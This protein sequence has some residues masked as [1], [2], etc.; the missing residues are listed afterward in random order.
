VTWMVFWMQKASRTMRADLERGAERALVSGS[1]WAIVVIG[2]VSVAR[3]GIE[4][5][6]M[7]WSLVRSFGNAPEAL[8]GA[9]LG[10]VLAV[11][12]GWLLQRGMVR[13]DLRVFFTWTGAVLIVA[14]AGVLAYG[15]H[16]LQEAGVLPGPF[17]SAAP[18]D[19]ASGAVATGVAG[20]PFGYAFDVSGAVSP[21]GPL[22]AVLQATVGFTPRMTW[23]QIVVWVAYLVVV[24]TV[25]ARRV[26]ASSAAARRR[27]AALVPLPEG[28][29]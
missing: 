23:L 11:A 24:G 17:T 29:R 9:L 6:L 13:L 3:E 19:P 12:L 22:A 27:A 14:A 18:H 28:A 20:F 1:M 5:T 2:F 10:L 8:A 21:S 15:C 25:F 26:R 7:L 4:T 16:D